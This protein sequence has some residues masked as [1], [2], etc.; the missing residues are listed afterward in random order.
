MKKEYK[1]IIMLLSFL[2]LILISSKINVS[3][4]DFKRLMPP[5]SNNINIVGKW[6]KVSSYNIKEKKTESIN[7]QYY[8]F[9]ENKAYIENRSYEEIEYKLRVI[10]LKNYLSFEYNIEDKIVQDDNIDADVMSILKNNGLISEVVMIDDNN[11]LAISN[12]YIYKLSKISDSVA[13]YP[14]IES[15]SNVTNNLM[16]DGD[17]SKSVGLYLGLKKDRQINESTTVQPEK[18]RTL[19]ISYEN[20][21]VQQVYQRDNILY[22]RLKGF[23]ELVPNSYEEDGKRYEYFDTYSINSKNQYKVTKGEIKSGE[24]NR[25][26]NLLYVGSNYISTEEFD[27]DY[28]AANS[29]F[30]IIPVDNIY[31]DKGVSVELLDGI[32]GYEA[33]KNAAE[34]AVSNNLD[35]RDFQTKLDTTNL[36]LVRKFGKWVLEGRYQENKSSKPIDFDIRNVEI[37]RLVNF[38]ELSVK[39]SIVKSENPMIRDIYS[40]PNGKLALLVLDENILVYEIE[41]GKLKGQPIKIIKKDKDESVIM[42]EWADGDFVR[43]WG[44]VFL[45]NASP[46]SN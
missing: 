21:E 42:T 9:S 2:V 30:K 27:Y 4:N 36:S 12:D 16:A 3:G 40:S 15:E 6:Q 8:Y 11:I 37:K 31:A 18:Y 1:V 35:S 10:N 43:M 7:N 28:T 32:Y 45:K 41:D 14:D 23:W 22:P 17:E 39:W 20:G 19:W 33:F 25:F 38:D 29:K 46:V 26:L 5:S 13:D 34:V 44:N 24:N